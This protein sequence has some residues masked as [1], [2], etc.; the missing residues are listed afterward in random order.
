MSSDSRQC[1]AEEKKT[2]AVDPVEE[3]REELP[4]LELPALHRPRK[5]SKPP[6][7]IIKGDVYIKSVKGN[8]YLVQGSRDEEQPQ[9]SLS[10]NRNQSRRS[11]LAGMTPQS[12]A[13]D[14]PSSAS[15]TD[16]TSAFDDTE[17][18]FI[19]PRRLAKSIHPPERPRVY[20][21][22]ER[23]HTSGRVSHT[24]QMSDTL[25]GK[26]KPRPASSVDSLLRP[27]RQESMEESATSGEFA[28][29]SFRSD[30]D[31]GDGI[32]AEEED[33]ESDDVG[34]CASHSR[35]C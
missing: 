34:T 29:G 9:R 11:Q 2:K 15:E 24:A 26:G 33:E 27:L 17:L 30:G 10:R 3:L 32:S 22:D 18:E 16:E 6:S 23:Y 35:L 31:D 19:P 20:R 4:H 28:A 14:D 5:F 21:A 8:V 7:S 13:Q 12:T 1:D 25:K